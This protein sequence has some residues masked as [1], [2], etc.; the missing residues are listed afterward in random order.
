LG[1]VAYSQIKTPDKTLEGSCWVVP[2]ALYDPIEQ[3]AVLLKGNKAARAFL[4]FVRSDEVREIIQ[5]Y[6]YG[7]P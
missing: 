5:G 4:A 2:Q 6:G 3:Q 7:T 1:F